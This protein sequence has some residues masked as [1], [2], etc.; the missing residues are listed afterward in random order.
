MPER[1]LPTPSDTRAQ[2]G[3]R[4][5]PSR[6]RSGPH[7]ARADWAGRRGGE[8]GLLGKGRPKTRGGITAEGSEAALPPR[9]AGVP[10][11]LAAGDR[12]RV[13]TEGGRGGPEGRGVSRPLDSD[14]ARGEGESSTPAGALLPH[15][16]EG[17]SAA[18]KSRCVSRSPGSQKDRVAQSCTTL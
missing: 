14:P 5:T 7:R 18:S 11:P 17:P 13:P 3:G 6:G 10:S 2:E 4:E 1:I 15:P 9:S 12:T 16:W 8:G